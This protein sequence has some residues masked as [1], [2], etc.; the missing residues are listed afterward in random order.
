MPRATLPW[1][2]DRPAGV[3]W[4]SRRI[5]RTGSFRWRSTV[6]PSLG[7]F[8]GDWVVAAPNGDFVVIGHNQDSHGR[9]IASTMVRY[10]SERDA[11]VAGGLLLGILP[12]N[13]AARGRRRG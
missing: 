2:R 3:I 6:S 7:T 5:R 4:P 9:P 12:F 11:P 1:C 13:W 8:V 10:A